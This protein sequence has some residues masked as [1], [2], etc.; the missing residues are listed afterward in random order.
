MEN[1]RIIERIVCGIEYYMETL[2]L[3]SHMEIYDDGIVSWIKPKE[4]IMGPAA[5]YK[6]NFADRPEDQIRQMIEAYRENG[7]PEYWCV[8]PLSATGLRDALVSLNMMAPKSDEDDQGMAI[9]PDQT[10]RIPEN[11]GIPV[12]RVANPEEFR[13]WTDICNE[14][15]HGCRLLDPDLYYPLCESEKM[16][17][18]L[19]Y[20]GETPV[21]TSAT[22]NNNGNGTLEFIS[23]LPDFRKKGIGA[24]VCRAAINQLIGDGA[25]LISLRARAMGVSLYASLGFKAYY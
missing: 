21:A 15:L 22:M 24:A 11:S 5:V 7:A 3:P 17:C 13:I 18:F 25:T 2:A 8:S 14:A 20:C 6:T 9:P 23:T 12:K 1:P 4:G 19:G 10:A 16:A